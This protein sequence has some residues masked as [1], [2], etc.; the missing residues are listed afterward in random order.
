MY[1]VSIHIVFVNHAIVGFNA[2]NI[3]AMRPTRW[4]ETSFPMP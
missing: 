3:A 1:E 4:S 2:N